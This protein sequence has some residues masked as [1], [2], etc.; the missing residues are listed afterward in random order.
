MHPEFRVGVLVDCEEMAANE[1]IAVRRLGPRL[2]GEPA[3]SDPSWVFVGRVGPL[4]GGAGRAACVEQAK[5]LASK[6][7]QRMR[8]LPKPPP[9]PP[10]PPT[11]DS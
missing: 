8:E 1:P 6:L 7:P 9:T 10:A 2:P 5:A 11:F 4:E 3:L